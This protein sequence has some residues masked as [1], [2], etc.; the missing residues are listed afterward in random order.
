VTRRT[1]VY[2]GSFDPPTNGH[3]DLIGRAAKL[4]DTVTVAVAENNAKNAFFT[5]EERIKLLEEVTHGLPGNIEITS[6]NGLTVDFAK[7]LGA[8]ALI[9]GLRV[10]SD[11]EYEL[12]MAIAN[13]KLEPS[14]E[15]VLLMPHEDCMLV[16]S[17]LVKEIAQFGG[18]LTQFVPDAIAER[19]KEKMAQ[20]TS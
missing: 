5:V 2:P 8:N 18:N 19:L 3:I 1:A 17:R 9:R 7:K 16:S 15:T 12:T 11:F 10:V 4:F 20:K 6:F 14:I 13:K